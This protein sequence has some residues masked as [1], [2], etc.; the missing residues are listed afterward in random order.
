MNS[1]GLSVSRISCLSTRSFSQTCSKVDSL[2]ARLAKQYVRPFSKSS[3]H[4][5]R[6]DPKILKPGPLKRNDRHP[7][8]TDSIIGTK[9]LASPG[10]ITQYKDLKKIDF[11]PEEGL[12]FRKEPLTQDEAIRIFGEGVDP[13]QAERILKV[14]QG[15][16]VSGILEDPD[17]SL[18]NK[19]PFEEWLT[20][21]GLQWLR[22]NVPVD[23]DTNAG[24]RADDELRA[25]EQETLEDSYNIGIWKPNSSGPG[26]KGAFEKLREAN[27]KARE[28]KEKEEKSQADEIRENTGT[29]QTS[30][31][32]RSR[33]ELRRPGENPK[34]KYYL[35]RAKILPDEP[36]EMTRF[37]RLWPSGL[38]VLTTLV[39]C[40]V[41]TN[42]Y[43]PPKNSKRLWPEIPPSVATVCG[44]L[45]INAAICLAWRMP[46]L[47]RFLNMTCILVPGYP[48]AWSIIGN[49]F[50]HQSITHLA[51]NLFMLYF[52]GTRLHEEIGRADFVATYM[53]CGVLAS[54]ASLV[55]FVLAKNFASATLGAS[56]AVFGI[57]ACYLTLN[58]GDR[59]TI[60]G[61]FPPENWPSMSSMGLLAFL[62]GVE[63]YSLWRKPAWAREI[64]S[65]S[66]LAG[67]LGGVGCAQLVMYRQRQRRDREAHRRKNMGVVG[68]IE[69]GK[70]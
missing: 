6:R 59:L 28:D 62:I 20:N 40:Y 43:T 12:P 44:I 56:G 9:T 15:W 58:S 38:V 35:E 65:W 55:S 46:P 11:D 25:L 37:A 4:C 7:N 70:M 42:V 10:I 67:L 57:I 54:Y 41:F 26:E 18:R 68:K 47:Y 27:K 3:S 16:R 33:V 17:E 21:L 50:S 32:P 5:A 36:P 34:L 1:L 53:A 14:L 29:L 19:I 69:E 2:A 49:V 61:V 60:F 51:G 13:A 66:H 24:L 30:D 23:E 39:G 63:I 8:A 31:G 22:A 64:D 52:F 45:L 48:F